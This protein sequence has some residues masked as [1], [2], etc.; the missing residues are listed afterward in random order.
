MSPAM[1]LAQQSSDAAAPAPNAAKSA[2]QLEE[3]V[4]TARKRSESLQNV[5]IAVTAF[6]KTA[7]GDQQ[8]MNLEGLNGAAPNLTLTKNQTTANSAQ[9]YIRGVGED[10]STPVNEPGV[11][12]YIDDVY[13]ARSQ[14]AL[15]DMLN[16]QQVEVLNGPQGTLYGRNSSGGAVKVVT[17]KPSLDAFSGDADLTVGSFDRVDFRAGVNMP[18]IQDKLGLSLNVLSFNSDGYVTDVATG[19]KIEGTSRQGVQSALRWKPASDVTVDLAFD[20]TRDNSGIQAPVPLAAGGSLSGNEKPLFGYYDSDPKAPDLNHFVG[21]GASADITWDRH[22]YLLKS[23]SAIRH[24]DNDFDGDLQGRGGGGLSSGGSFLFRDLHDTQYTQELQ[25]VSDNSSRLSY[26]GGLFYLH[27]DMH[28]LD[29]FL[30]V[31]NYHQYTDSLAAYG[32]LTYKITDRLSLTG[33]GRFS[34]DHKSFQINA[35]G[36]N[37]PFAVGDARKAFNDF[38]PKVSLSYQETAHALAYATWQEGYK[39]GAFQGFP[40]SASDVTTQ[41]LNPEKVSSYE[42]GEKTEWLDN[43][44]RLNADIYYENYSNLQVALFNFLPGGVFAFQSANAQ[45]RMYG[46]EFQAQGTLSSELSAYLTAGYFHGEYTGAQASVG[47]QVRLNAGYMKFMPD[48][49]MKTGLNYRHPIANLGYFVANVNVSYTTREYF[50]TDIVL[51]N[52]QAP[53][54]LVD[55]KIGFETPERKWGVYIGGQNITNVKWASTGTTSGGGSLFV[56]PPATWSVTLAAHF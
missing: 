3:V 50:S 10:D 23:I 45:A 21:G 31:D 4:V 46:A 24:F 19:K 6:S 54:E 43:K 17:I 27:E 39:A 8:V 12:V 44:L 40:Q 7:L 28:N 2:A 30:L 55:A 36:F 48:F 53:H 42:I 25:I 32:E 22:G 52:S 26:V 41:I 35:V 18:V 1:A 11:A 47:G 56:E 20:F 13:I 38:T 5:P 15:F 14:G 29:D 37:G 9:I 49:N 33:G 16:V 34:Y 51:S